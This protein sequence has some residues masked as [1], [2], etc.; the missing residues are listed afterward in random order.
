M[1]ERRILHTVTLSFLSNWERI[2]ERQERS[3]AASWFDG[4]MAARFRGKNVLDRVD[5]STRHIIPNRG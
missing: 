4:M 2:A 3:R 5:R 1:R